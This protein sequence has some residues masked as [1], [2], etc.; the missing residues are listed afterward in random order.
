MANGFAQAGDFFARAMQKQEQAASWQAKAQ[1]P[2]M[3]NFAG[4]QQNAPGSSDFTVGTA[5]TLPSLEAAATGSSLRQSPEIVSEL[6][7]KA[8]AKRAQ[9]AFDG[10]EP[11]APYQ[12]TN[13]YTPE[14]STVGA[15]VTPS[16]RGQRIAPKIG[17][18]VRAGQI[19]A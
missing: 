8:K 13:G 14:I 2:T 9:S 19:S 18:S 4:I 5:P 11:P 6:L 17:R 3:N 1:L 16:V 15:R 10:T 12:P 7:S